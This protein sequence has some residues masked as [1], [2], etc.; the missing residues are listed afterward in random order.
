MRALAAC[1]P[2]V[3]LLACTTGSSPGGGQPRKCRAIEPNGPDLTGTSLR[4]V[5]SPNCA[6]VE[7]IQL[8]AVSLGRGVKLRDGTVLRDVSLRA[9]AL[10]SGERPIEDFTGAELQGVAETGESVRVTIESIARG[11]T[12][13][14]AA[15][16]TYLYRL[17]YRFADRP[18][19]P[20][21][22]VCPGGEAAIAIPGSWDLRTSASGGGGKR[23]SSAT[24]VTFGCPRSAVAKCAALLGYLPWTSA[25]LDSLHQSC[26]RAVRADYCGDGQSMT[27]PDENVNFYDSLGLQRDT[28]DWR[29]EAQWTP[30]GARCVGTT[31]LTTAPADPRTHRP[32]IKVADYLSKACPQLPRTCTPAATA[33][34]ADA[35]SLSTEVGPSAGP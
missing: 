8:G 25:A 21:A 30:Q 15:E 2:L 32:E 23:S 11:T 12:P 17:N 31:R 19:E 13:P 7:G 6:A 1:S 10:R 24:E 18:N 26:V 34:A 33:T 29:I 28:A 16:P 14:G 22:P 27:R 4:R 3:L 9:D 5:P 35:P 20:A